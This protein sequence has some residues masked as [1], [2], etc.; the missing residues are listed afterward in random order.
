MKDFDLKAYLQDLENV[1][2]IDS[3][4][5]DVEGVNKVSRYFQELLQDKYY[6]KEFDLGPS[7]GFSTLITNTEE[8]SYDVLMMAHVDTVFHKGTVAARPF[9]IEEGVGYGPG[10]SDMKAGGLVGVYAMANCAE[11][12]KPLKIALSLN[13]EEEQSSV[14]IRPLLEE[15]SKKS[16]YVIILEPA[17]ANG[18]HV[19]ERKGLGRYA[20][21]FKGVAAHSGVN[22]A[23]GRS[24]IH[25]MAYWVN[26]LTELHSLETGFTVNVGEVNGGTGANI[27]A[28]HC[29]IVIDIR[30]TQMEQ[31]KAWDGL[32]EELKLHAAA[33]EIGVTID[34][35]VKRPPMFKTA[36][37]DE[38][39]A[40][41]NE[42]AAASGLDC[43]WVKTGGGSDGN[44]SAAL[45]IPTVDG[46]GPIGGAAHSDKEYLEIASIEPDYHLLVNT[47]L[48]LRNK[49]Y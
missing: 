41:I 47:L 39:I 42:T 44:F 25:E 20:I 26:K 43:R 40:L 17:R 11:E 22:P 36:A 30:L 37:T 2:N 21:D 1:V 32:L 34:G 15:L 29:G 7:R 4:A 49:L 3:H 46:M 27:V 48:A 23:D 10:V 28:E 19:E 16:K 12:L 35:W 13:P 45:G 38:F 33:K 24:A 5:E 14:F 9:K 6:I 31:I 18:A 8:D